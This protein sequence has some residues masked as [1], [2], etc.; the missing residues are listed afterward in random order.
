MVDTAHNISDTG[1]GY[2]AV[3]PDL[4]VSGHLDLAAR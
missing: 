1:A 3:H 2:D 4:A